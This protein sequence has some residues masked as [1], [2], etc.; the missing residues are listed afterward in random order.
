MDKVM[1]E[2]F[3]KGFQKVSQIETGE[4]PVSEPEEKPSET[5]VTCL[6]DCQYSQNPEKRCMLESVSI[7]QDESES[8]M[9][10]QFTPVAQQMEQPMPQE[11]PP[12]ANMS[13]MKQQPN[14]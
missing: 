11:Q 8:F 13:K 7:S 2:H 9:C 10:G 1:L 4:D 14:Q 5:Q 3:K 12:E 6:S